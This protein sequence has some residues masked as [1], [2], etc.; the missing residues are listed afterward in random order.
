MYY[1]F[2]KVCLTRQFIKI[3]VCK[4]IINNIKLQNHTYIFKLSSIEHKNK[5]IIHVSTIVM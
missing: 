2:I 1:R 5:V 4:S 3:V